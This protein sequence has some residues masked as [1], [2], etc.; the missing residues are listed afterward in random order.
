MPNAQCSFQ[1]VGG[2][3]LGELEL[4]ELV[5]PGLRATLPQLI[6]KQHMYLFLLSLPPHPSDGLTLGRRPGR[7]AALS[8]QTDRWDL[9][10][11]EGVD[12]SGLV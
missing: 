3:Q 11:L 4:V 7:M 6:A 5:E 12:W 2:H 1:S 8:L 9:P 10:I